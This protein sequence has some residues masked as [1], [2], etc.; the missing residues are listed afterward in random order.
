MLNNSSITRRN[1]KDGYRHNRILVKENEITKKIIKQ[2]YS[3]C[4][5]ISKLICNDNNNKIH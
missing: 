3:V 4:A 1:T 5:I 2:N